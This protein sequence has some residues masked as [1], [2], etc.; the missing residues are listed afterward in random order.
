MTGP[1]SWRQLQSPL[2]QKVA[3]HLQP[4]LCCRPVATEMNSLLTKCISCSAQAQHSSIQSRVLSSCEHAVMLKAP[5]HSHSGSPEAPQQSC[6]HCNVEEFGTLA[7]YSVVSTPF[8][9]CLGTFP[10][11][12]CR[13][14]SSVTLAQITVV[15]QKGAVLHALSSDLLRGCRAS[16]SVTTPL[17]PSTSR[18]KVKSRS[19]IVAYS[20]RLDVAAAV[21]AFLTNLVKVCQLAV[22]HSVRASIQIR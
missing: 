12:L 10:S 19:E 15:I 21:C 3:H 1:C 9:Y 5:I 11:N 13:H 22:R 4:G 2:R 17:S 18:K 7:L 16:G 8:Y 14:S 6:V 20:S